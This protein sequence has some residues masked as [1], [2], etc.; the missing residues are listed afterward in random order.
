MDNTWVLILLELYHWFSEVFKQ[1]TGVLGIQLKDSTESFLHW[2]GH[3]H[4]KTMR[5]KQTNKKSESNLVK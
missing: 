3:N 5:L 4:A 1:R 2:D